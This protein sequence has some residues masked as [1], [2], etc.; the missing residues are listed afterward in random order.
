MRIGQQISGDWLGNHQEIGE[1]EK[2]WELTIDFADRWVIA[3]HEGVFHPSQGH[4]LRA[5]SGRLSKS[6]AKV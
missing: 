5:K 4:Y 1:A 3:D 6:S 2:A